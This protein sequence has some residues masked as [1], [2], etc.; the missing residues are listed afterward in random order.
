MGSNELSA[1]P[2]AAPPHPE[3]PGG[4]RMAAPGSAAAAAAAVAAGAVAAAAAGA[5][6]AAAAGA[7]APAAA[8]AASAPA[9]L[10]AQRQTF[11]TFTQLGPQLP[12]ASCP[13]YVRRD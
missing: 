6:G 4:A 1:S 7:V 2:P 8:T 9:P 3:R 10:L 12:L 5:A 11:K 13:L